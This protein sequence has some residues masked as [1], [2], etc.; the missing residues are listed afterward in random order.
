MQF[1]N[2]ISEN[3]VV[4]L[5]FIGEIIFT[6]TPSG[7]YVLFHNTPVPLISVVP[8]K[9]MILGYCTDAFLTALIY[10]HV[11]RKI[12]PQTRLV[13]VSTVRMIRH[14]NMTSVT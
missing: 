11:Q 1:N 13:V 6:I 5:M 9:L 3:Y 8:F 2:V 12:A 10:S 7:L 4:L 14:N